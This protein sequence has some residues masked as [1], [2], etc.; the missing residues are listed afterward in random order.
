LSSS[1]LSVAVSQS[2]ELELLCERRD[3][4]GVETREKEWFSEDDC[5]D[6]VGEGV[7]NG[8][9]KLTSWLPVTLILPPNTA[10][11]VLEASEVR[12][13]VGVE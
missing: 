8:M 9:A 5:E 1:P 6:V 4:D 11:T 2:M 10:F 7:E 12:P 13:T 3:G